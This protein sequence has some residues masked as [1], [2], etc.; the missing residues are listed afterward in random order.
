MNFEYLTLTSRAQ[1]NKVNMCGAQVNERH[2]N[3]L[4][5]HLNESDIIN[6]KVKEVLL[7]VTIC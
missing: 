2:M 6:M 1:K 3:E 5:P 4:I 7:K